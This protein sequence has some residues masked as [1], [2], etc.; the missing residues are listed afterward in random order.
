[1]E[2][3]KIYENDDL[4]LAYRLDPL[5]L[6]LRHSSL[7]PYYTEFLDEAT[8]HKIYSR[9]GDINRSEKYYA[10]LS[11]DSQIFHIITTPLAT[12]ATLQESIKLSPLL[13][14]IYLL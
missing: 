1:L 12:V 7:D 6:E 4:I 8:Q 3:D 11:T 10:Y 9:V 14:E 13:S 2:Q 5:M